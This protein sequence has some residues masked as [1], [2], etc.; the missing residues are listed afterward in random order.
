MDNSATPQGLHGPPVFDR[1]L[2]AA[3]GTG[4][5][6]QLNDVRDMLKTAIGPTRPLVMLCPHA[7]DGAIT[8]ACLIH[9][10]AVRRGLPWYQEVLVLQGNRTHLK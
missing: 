5:H 4:L 6:G 2:R 10:Y 8:A 9:E 7:D 1:M 3:S